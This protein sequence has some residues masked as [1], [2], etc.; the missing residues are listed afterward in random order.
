[1]WPAVVA[2]RLLAVAAQT[3]DPLQPQSPNYNF[4]DSGRL[5]VQPQKPSYNFQ[6]SG[7]IGERRSFAVLLGPP[8]RGVAVP[9]QRATRLTSG[10]ACGK[11]TVAGAL[12]YTGFTLVL[13]YYL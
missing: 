5:A 9:Q 3:H 4:Q 7:R 8:P 10:N 2:Q 1:M 13:A 11:T 6:G 12:L